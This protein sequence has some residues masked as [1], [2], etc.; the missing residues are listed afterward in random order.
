MERKICEKCGASYRYENDFEEHKRLGCK[1]KSAP[2]KA[3]TFSD[4]DAE[5]AP[6]S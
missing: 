3:K 6:Q 4:K 2:K 5:E 1:M